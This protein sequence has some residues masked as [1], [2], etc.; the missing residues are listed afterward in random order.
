MT[1]YI[2]NTFLIKNCIKKDD[3][4]F[5]NSYHHAIISNTENEHKTYTSSIDC[6]I[7]L[8]KSICQQFLQIL[9]Y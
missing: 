8:I 6:L 1:F 4:Y 7:I 3:F 2:E 5:T 9:V